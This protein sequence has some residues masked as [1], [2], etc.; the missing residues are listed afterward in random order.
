M[1]TKPFD[2]V[3]MVEQ[4]QAEIQ[5]KLEAMSR[6]EELAF[7]EAQTEKLRERQRNA[8]REPQERDRLPK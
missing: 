2:C 6:E 3:E 5:D 4:A 8:Q 1:T 7:W